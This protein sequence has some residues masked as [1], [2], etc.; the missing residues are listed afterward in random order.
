MEELLW[1]ANQPAASPCLTYN[2]TWIYEPGTHASYS[3]TNFLLCGYIL[4]TFMPEGRNDYWYQMDLNYFLGLNQNEYQHLRFAPNGTLYMLGLST[5][6][7]SL[8][9]GE[10]M[11]YDQDNSIMAWTGGYVLSNA[12]DVARFY[13]DLMGPEYK[14][15]NQTSIEEMQQWVLLDIGFMAG[16][17][18][19][20]L[21]LMIMDEDQARNQPNYTDNA[22]IMIGHGGSTYGYKSS[23]GYNYHI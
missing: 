10:A 14:I 13:Y 4:Q 23:Q 22:G 15:L 2:C 7:A 18:Y 8:G 3:T 12:L 5:A 9:F 19:Y 20:G 21:G 17:L 11:I 16:E 1:V 6:G